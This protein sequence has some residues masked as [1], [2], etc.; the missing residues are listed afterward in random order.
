[1]I[2]LHKIK[3]NQ[4]PIDV[5]AVQDGNEVH[6]RVKGTKFPFVI[7]KRNENGEPVVGLNDAD[8]GFKKWTSIS[9]LRWMR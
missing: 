9:L 4:D 5:E 3:E 6:L 8:T 7:C 2:V 1:M